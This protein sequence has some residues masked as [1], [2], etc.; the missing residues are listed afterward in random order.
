MDDYSTYYDDLGVPE[1]AAPEQIRSAYYTKI[2]E[3][4][5]DHFQQR[6]DWVKHQAEETTKILNESYSVLSDPAKREKYDEEIKAFREHSR[7]AEEEESRRREEEERLRREA[8]ERL[9]RDEASKR[10]WEEEQRLHREATEKRRREEAER[11]RRAEEKE[12]LRREVERRRRLIFGGGAVVGLVAIIVAL[13]GSVSVGSDKK[14]TPLTPTTT[15]EVVLDYTLNLNQMVAIGG[16]DQT[17]LKFDHENFPVT[18]KKGQEK[19]ELYLIPFGSSIRQTEILPKIDKMGFRPAGLREL[20]AFGA[21]YPNEQRKYDIFALGSVIVQSDAIVVPALSG[22]G[23]GQCGRCLTGTPAH[24]TMRN[25]FRAGDWT[26]YTRYLALRKDEKNASTTTLPLLSVENIPAPDF[27][28]TDPIEVYRYAETKNYFNGRIPEFEGKVVRISGVLKINYDWP[29]FIGVTG[30][31]FRA[32]CY[33]IEELPP[34]TSIG[35]RITIQGVFLEIP[36][37]VRLKS[38]VVVP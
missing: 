16:Y 30:T 7:R 8:S 17:Y 3:Y 13:V 18:E 23:S 24:S 25:S 35:K 36:A 4:H 14:T 27:T 31:G 10:R 28:F 21:Q 22:S 15:F 29:R 20:L 32:R 11:H 34:T 12:R 9:R 6:P 5:P 37:E 26:S 38:C 33:S 1:D 19:V 2:K